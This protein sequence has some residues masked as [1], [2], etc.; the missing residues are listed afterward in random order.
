[1]P[2]TPTTADA[3][4]TAIAAALGVTDTISINKYKQVYEILY[5]AL[6]VDITATL[7]ANTVITVGSAATQTGPTTPVPVVIS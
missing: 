5:A 1:M 3:V 7:S 2:L 4:A 6:L